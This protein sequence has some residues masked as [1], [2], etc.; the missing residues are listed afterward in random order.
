MK[1]F[2]WDK[3]D[4][5]IAGCRRECFQVELS[6]AGDHGHADAVAIAARY[7]R[8]EHL[9]RRKAD[10]ASHALR[11]KIIRA[12][13]TDATGSAVLRI[14]TDAGT[15][16]RL[17][18]FGGMDATFVASGPSLAAVGDD[19]DLPLMKE[20]F[21]ASEWAPRPPEGIET[22]IFGRT[23]P[24]ELSICACCRLTRLSTTLSIACT[25]ASL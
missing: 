6:V 10:L 5:A 21:L 11:G 9:L 15:Q 22:A 8:F 12:T 18:H 13:A 4:F 24:R 7:E 14:D 17:L 20:H 3:L 2:H 25:A 23:I 1:F 19:R 16:T